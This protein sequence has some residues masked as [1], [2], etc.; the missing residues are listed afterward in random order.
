MVR[1]TCWRV[2]QE[3]KRAGGQGDRT[4]SGQRVLACVAGN[5]AFMSERTTWCTRV[6]SPSSTCPESLGSQVASGS[7][8]TSFNWSMRCVWRG[9]V[10][11]GKF[12]LW[13]T[14]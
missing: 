10:S 13:R 8:R 6:T 9:A 2:G 7:T 11:C 5:L 3:G 1:G 4:W 12:G 14:D